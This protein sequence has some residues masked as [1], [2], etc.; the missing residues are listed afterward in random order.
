MDDIAHDVSV[1][2]FGCMDDRLVPE[3]AAKVGQQGG[4]FLVRMA[5]GPAAILSHRD[6]ESAI[7]QLV[8]ACRAQV[9]K[10]I[11]LILHLDCWKVTDL[12][13]RTTELSYWLG[14]P[15]DPTSVADLYALGDIAADLVKSAIFRELNI[16]MLV[17]VQVEGL[18]RG[19]DGQIVAPVLP[20]P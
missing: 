13:S 5:G 12:A 4:G 9:P 20:R 10:V 16:R 18:E 2:A 11:I 14:H 6:N 17:I 8:D 19:P 7:G 1:A 3:H 15:V